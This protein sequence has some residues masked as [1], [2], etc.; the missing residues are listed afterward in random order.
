MQVIQICL[1]NEGCLVGPCWQDDNG[2]SVRWTGTQLVAQPRPR[3]IGP[4][5]ILRMIPCLGSRDVA[6]RFANASSLMSSS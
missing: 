2:H 1:P 5:A 3:G 6:L 4:G